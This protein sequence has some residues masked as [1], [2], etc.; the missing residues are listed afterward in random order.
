MTVVPLPSS[1]IDPA[2]VARFSAI[3]AQWWDPRGK[4][5]PLHRFNPARLAF[6]R[7]QALTR[8]GSDP[9]SRAPFEGLRLLDIGCGGGLLCEPMA[10]LG[11]SVVGAD[12]SERNI[13]V[14]GAHAAE[15]GLNI[16][17]RVA[18]VEALL[19]AGEPPFDLILNM[20]VVEHV[21]DPGAF[22]RDGARLLAPGGLMIVAT[23]NRTLEALALAKIGAEYL[24]RWLPVG[25]H[26]WRKFITPEEMRGH[27][28]GEGH[29]IEGPFGVAYNPLTGRWSRSTGARVN[30]LM[31]IG[32]LSP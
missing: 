12:A 25:T 13:A 32:R 1:S 26:Q 18:T 8:F 17:Y 15:G 31:T 29:T 30:Y 22:L 24:L 14:A 11:F 21:A 4:F 2:E 23:L 19:A 28:A 6:I 27:L 20:E 3:A 16:D 10:R 7:E 9:K 5:A